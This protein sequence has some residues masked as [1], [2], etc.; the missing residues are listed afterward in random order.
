MCV[1]LGHRQ[2]VI[3]YKGV[4][5][6][7]VSTVV[8]S[9]DSTKSLSI[10][11]ISVLILCRVVFLGSNDHI[12]KLDFQKGNHCV[13]RVP[14]RGCLLTHA[15]SVGRSIDVHDVLH[16]WIALLSHSDQYQDECFSS[17]SV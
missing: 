11:M 10:L 15:H 9:M 4:Y 7:K 12:C 8:G 17:M 3:E 14:T 13:L 5:S 6:S 16:L 2:E 1:C